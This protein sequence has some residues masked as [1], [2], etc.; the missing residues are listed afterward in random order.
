MGEF[1]SMNLYLGEVRKI[2]YPTDPTS[3]T[4]QFIE[5]SVTVQYRRGNGPAASV[6]F[7]NCLPANLFG[8][9]ADKFRY[10][11]RA[12]T[13]K[14][15]QNEVF[16]DGSKVLLLC[17]NGESSKAYIL[18]GIADPTDSPDQMS[19]G[20]NVFFEFNGTQVTINDSGELQVMFR[21]KTQIDG[22][23]DSSAVAAAEGTKVFF[24][25]NGGVKVSTPSDAQ[26]VYVDHQNK[27]IDVLA[28]TEW[29]VKVNGKLKFETGD[30][31]SINGSSGMDVT[32]SNNI[33]M[34]SSGV[35]V[36]GATDKW[37]LFTTY[38]IAQQTMDSS[39]ISLL[40]TLSSL[41]AT[42]GATLTTA[43]GVMVTPV[44]GA[45]AAAPAIAA[46]GAA[47][48]AA[49]PIFAALASAITSFESG[50]A[51]YESLKNKN[52]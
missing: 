13:Q 46:A 17:L 14:P 20:H 36:G 48:T 43:G 5:Y 4:K 21:G 41:I 12:A 47:L 23:L 52:D 27:K 3:V 2:I 19:D 7:S 38:R 39:S 15:A 34:N 35:L 30:Q 9:I 50:A 31:I 33:T 28:D 18:G 42:A 49:G 45:I 32:T 26:F 8:G 11:L 51:T 22:T 37:P 44:A 25:K 6:D 40:T 1:T 16:S 24:D 10:T 29:H